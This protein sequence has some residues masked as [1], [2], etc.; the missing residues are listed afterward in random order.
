[1]VYRGRVENSKVELAPE[2]QLPDGLEVQVNVDW[3][4]SSDLSLEEDPLYRMTDFAVET[5]LP[6]DLAANIDHYLYGHPKAED[7]R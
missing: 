1:M 2:V 6:S 5:G 7:G 3:P 4:K